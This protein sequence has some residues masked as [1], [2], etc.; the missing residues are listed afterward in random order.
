MHD[1]PL[2]LPVLAGRGAQCPCLAGRRPVARS[3]GSPGPGG[4]AN[5][6]SGN[7]AGLR[8]RQQHGLRRRHHVAHP[9]GHWDLRHHPTGGGY[10]PE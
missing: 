8:V 2:L 4:N 5:S 6:G 7:L 3:G 9:L 10:G 1:V